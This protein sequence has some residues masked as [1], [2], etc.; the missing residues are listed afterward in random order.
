M[1]MVQLAIQD[2]AYRTALEQA[3][4]DSGS[5]QV[6][7]VAAPDPRCG[8]V[9][10]LD[11][12]ALDRVQGLLASPERVVLIT[13]KDPQHLARAW[14]AGVISVVFDDDPVSTAMLAVMSAG[15]RAP[16]AP[17]GRQAAAGAFPDGAAHPAHDA[18]V[19]GRLGVGPRNRAG[20]CGSRRAHQ[21]G[22]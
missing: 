13:H 12:Q 14:E 18:G 1:Q 11:T 3:L 2:A 9:I 17:P 8:G 5:W 19:K 22:H 6:V 10:V 21:D 15:L 16:H 4:G 20:H 7:S